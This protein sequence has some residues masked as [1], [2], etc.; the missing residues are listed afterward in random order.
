VQSLAAHL[1]ALT[2]DQ[3]TDLVANRRDAT[4]EPAPQ[5][6]DQL[7]ARLL[8]PSSMASACAMLTLP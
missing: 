1:R 8:H 7:A 3:L 5:S 2:H 6:A 4:I